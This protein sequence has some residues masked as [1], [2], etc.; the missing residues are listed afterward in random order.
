LNSELDL[1]IIFD[2]IENSDESHLFI[3]VLAYQCVQAIRNILRG[4]GINESWA[5]IRKSL[6]GH[7]RV[8]F[9]FPQL[10]NSWI[11]VRKT[12]VPNKYQSEIYRA[13]RLTKQE[14]VSFKIDHLSDID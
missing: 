3:T 2:S 6:A 9:N 12:L 14:A 10:D 5:Y 7:G 1:K 8:T 11:C 4:S 13:L